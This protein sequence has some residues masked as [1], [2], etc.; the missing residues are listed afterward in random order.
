[1]GYCTDGKTKPDNRE[2]KKVEQE[3]KKNTIDTYKEALK[4]LSQSTDD[5]L[6]LFDI[7][8]DENYFFGNVDADYALREENSPVNTTAQMLQIIYGADRAVLTK[9]LA[10]IASGKKD[11]HNMEYRWVT[12]SGEVR[13]ISCRGRVIKDENGKSAYMIG[14]VSEEAVRHLYNP[15]TGLFNQ[16]KL[17]IDLKKSLPQ[18]TGGYIML[19][20]ID[21]LSAINLSHGRKYGDRLLKDMASAIEELDGVER[22]Y[23]TERNYFA[24]I[25]NVKTISDVQKAYSLLQSAMSDRCTFTAGVAPMDNTLF[26]N[27]NNLYDCVKIILRKAKSK[28]RNNIEFF[29]REEI[30]QKIS[31]V[32]L[33]EE[34]YESVNNNFRG[35]YINYQ[36]QVR[37]GNYTLYSAEAL[38]RYTSKSG[39]RVFPDEFIPLLEQSK[40]IIDVGDWV[41]RQALLQCKKWRETLKDMR[42]S[43]NFSMV[44]FRERYIVDSVL[45]ALKDTGMQ[46]DALTIEITES[47]PTSEIDH[48]IAVIK[49]LKEAG[50]QIAIDDFG[51]G[52]SNL[53]YL[54]QL[55]IDE[56]KIDR[57]FVKGIEEDTYNYRLVSNTLDFAKTNSIRVCCEGVET[58]R[59]L[60]ILESRSPDLIQGY[61]FDKPC[62]AEEFEQAYIDSEAQKYKDRE[63]FINKLYEYK[64]KA[65]IIHFD[66]KDILRET[67]VGLWVIRI[68]QSESYCE[69]HVDETM[70]RI[71]ALDKKYTPQECYDFWFGRIKDECKDYVKK[72]I[73]HMCEV[74]KVVQLQYSWQHPTMGEVTVR[75]SGRRTKDADGMIV[76]EGYHRNFSQI[77]EA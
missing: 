7:A 34:M 54:K 4:I 9:D 16:T 37:A 63:A 48:F 50:I 28:G 19:I 71:M 25:L 57:M 66:P 26:V 61:L 20:D 21:D 69:L 68:N 75:S 8:R 45:A 62:E 74:S 17:M 47:V 13:W 22:V 10:E 35:F 77:E 33:L 1:M 14:R 24:V 42:V 46:G 65:N 44:Q 23:H 38:L 11:V 64:E 70:E 15:L 2:V 31:S 43:V 59:E 40:L 18:R 67:N 55:D 76:L 29:S 60:A 27:E 5:F 53:G 72:S 39:E 56:I 36:P 41:L 12:R 32:E 58:T 6:F 49:H 73:D 30:E 52:Y 3:I 51:T